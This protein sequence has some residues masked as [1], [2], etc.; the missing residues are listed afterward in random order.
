MDGVVVLLVDGA[1]QLEVTNLIALD[2]LGAEEG[3]RCLGRDGGTDGHLAG[4]DEDKTVTLGLPGK[5]D[6]SVLDGINN[7]DG[8]TLLLDA[9]DFEVGCQ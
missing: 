7:L 8:H 3:N 6:N 9:E 5:V 4:G 1:D 2:L